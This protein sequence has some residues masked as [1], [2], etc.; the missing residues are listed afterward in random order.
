M[1]TRR[2]LVMACV[3]A[4]ALVAGPSAAVADVEGPTT[5]LDTSC[6]GVVATAAEAQA[7]Q[8]APENAPSRGDD[9]VY[10]GVRLGGGVACPTPLLALA[11]VR[12]P[13]GVTPVLGDPSHPPVVTWTG[14][15]GVTAALPPASLSLWPGGEPG[16]ARLEPA[17]G[18]AGFTVPPGGR[19]Q[20]WVPVRASRALNGPVGALPPCALAG[21]DGVNRTVCPPSARGD[22]VQV[23]LTFSGAV[24]DTAV[25]TSPMWVSAP[26]SAAGGAVAGTGPGGGAPG[27]PSAPDGPGATGGAARPGSPASDRAA[28][29][30]RVSVPRRVSTRS[31]VS[32]VVVRVAGAPRGVRVRVRLARGSRILA[33]SA[34]RTDSAGRARARLRLAAPRARG[35]AGR[36]L[37][38]RV[39]VPGADPWAALLRVTR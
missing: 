27:S 26:A 31:L 20:M 33:V 32:G 10:V 4:G 25:L 5:S 24:S 21:T 15:D 17:D 18:R 34:P 2:I 11:E 22:T 12:P 19:L 13:S 35:L 28:A 8:R 9:V 14:P 39:D 6:R 3:A 23:V 37:S 30:P 1:V 36:T 29:R 16:A 38:V 7:A